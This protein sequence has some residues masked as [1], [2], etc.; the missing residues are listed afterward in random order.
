MESTDQTFEEISR[1][2]KSL[3]LVEDR[4]TIV[5]LASMPIA[6]RGMTNTMRIKQIG[7]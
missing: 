1:M 4:D 6:S 3:S 2:L 5:Q 7:H